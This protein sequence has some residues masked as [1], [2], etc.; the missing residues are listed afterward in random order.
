MNWSRFKTHY[1]H[2]AS[3]DL[4]LEISRLPFPDD[5]FSSMEPAM[6]RAFDA[7]T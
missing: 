3:L 2:N 6:Q 1:Y 5:F 4:S 7:M